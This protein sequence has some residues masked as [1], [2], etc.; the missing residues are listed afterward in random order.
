L[1]DAS[2]GAEKFGDNEEE[3]EEEEEEGAAEWDARSRSCDGDAPGGT[4]TRR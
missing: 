1:T 4:L 2:L 3:E